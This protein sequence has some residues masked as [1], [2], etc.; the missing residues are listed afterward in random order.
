[1][2]HLLNRYPGPLASGPLYQA[3]IYRFQVPGIFHRAPTFQATHL[4]A[5]LFAKYHR[6]EDNAMNKDRIKIA[7]EYLNLQYGVSRMQSNK[8]YAES[9]EP[10]IVSVVRYPIA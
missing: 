9:I 5:P 8:R 7:G 4:P 1:M 6:M 10:E 2:E 3:W